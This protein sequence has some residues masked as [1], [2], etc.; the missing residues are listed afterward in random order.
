MSN[1]LAAP[2]ANIQSALTRKHEKREKQ[3]GICAWLRNISHAPFVEC[4]IIF[5][6]IG[7][8]W[9]L[10]TYGLWWPMSRWEGAKLNAS[11][12]WLTLDCLGMDIYPVYIFMVGFD[13]NL[14]PK[15]CHGRNLKMQ[16]DTVETVQSWHVVVH[17]T[18]RFETTEGEGHDRYLP[19]DIG[20]AIWSQG[21]CLFLLKELN[22]PRILKITWWLWWL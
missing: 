8:S 7:C 2:I 5:C 18:W 22:N 12:I 17:W 9:F 14:C 21:W 11:I 3:S 10:P 6:R 16:R 4:Y 20:E 1:A 19:Y 15:V 13:S